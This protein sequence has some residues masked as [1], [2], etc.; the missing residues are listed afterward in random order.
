MA[1]VRRQTS[2]LPPRLCGQELFLVACDV[3][4]EHEIDRPPQFVGEERQRLALA[5]SGGE[6]C[7][8]LFGRL[9]IL[10]KEHRRFREGPLE[11][12]VADLL[13]A[14]AVAFTIRL[15]G[16]FDQAA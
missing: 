15:L 6:L 12:R 3:I 11:V 4:L 16:A 14:G 2:P 13:A 8:V 9:V 7:Q 10:E 5:V 1:L